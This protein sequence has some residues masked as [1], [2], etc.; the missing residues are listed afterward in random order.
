MR[1]TK[2]WWAIMFWGLGIQ[3]VNSY[4]LYVKYMLS[5]GMAKKNYYRSTS[6]G[7][8]LRWLGLTLQTIG[9]IVMTVRKRSAG[10]V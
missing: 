4:I 7:R 8:T 6:F 5:E 3:L 2:W 1:K 9:L 10:Q